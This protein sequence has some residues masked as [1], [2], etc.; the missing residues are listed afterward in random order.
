MIAR[1]YAQVQE[2][3]PA[4][5]LFGDGYAYDY[6]ALV[7]S[8][9]FEIEADGHADDYQGDSWYLFRDPETES[10]GYLCFGWGSCSG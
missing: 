4:A 6:K 3:T 5:T 7:D 1:T 10:W 8:F 2:E 9:G